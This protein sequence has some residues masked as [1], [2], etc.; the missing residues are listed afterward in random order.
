LKRFDAYC[1][2]FHPEET[3]L[4]KRVVRGWFDYEVCHGFRGLDQKSGAI[5]GFANFVGDGS[6]I[7]PANLYPKTPEYV[8]YILSDEELA[9]FFHAVDCFRHARD[10]FLRITLMVLLRLIYACGL[11]PN[12]GRNLLTSHI[13]FQ[14]GELFITKTKRR[15]ERY[16]V[17]S[18]EMLSIMKQYRKA[19]CAITGKTDL[20]FTYSNGQPISSKKL[21]K[22]VKQCWVAANP[23]IPVENLPSL[24]VYDL[25]HRFASAVLQ[26]WLDEGRNL[27]SML[28]YL[29]TYMGHVKYEDTAYYIHLLPDRLIKSPGI[30]WDN[31]DKTGLEEDIWNT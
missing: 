22:Y 9:R 11:R 19:R 26:K 16:V 28:P 7:L 24:R 30:K 10:P 20:F 18:D 29:R 23:D 14:T 2:E 6:Y 15:K 17:M 21:T 3:E 27:Y 25:R 8:P 1:A 12:E 31:I 4:T 13:N 5:R